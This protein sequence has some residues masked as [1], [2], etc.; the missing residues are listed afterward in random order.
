[1]SLVWPSKKLLLTAVFLLASAGCG[2]GDPGRSGGRVA[3]PGR[4][5]APAPRGTLLVSPLPPAAPAPLPNLDGPGAALV[6]PEGTELAGARAGRPIGRLKGGIPVRVSAVED[7]WAKILTPCEYE[8]WVPVSSMITLPRPRVVLDP[9]HGGGESGAVGPAGLAEKSVNLA[10]A[11]RAAELLHSRGIAALLTRTDDYR[12]TIGFRVELA[13]A[14]RP[15]LL[16]SIHHNAEPDGPRD[17]PGTETFYQIGSP[18]SRRLAGLMYEEAIRFLSPLQA[19]WVA[20]RDAGAKWR[21]NSSGGDYYG[22]L[23]RAR[24]AGI[25]AI[26]AELAFISN[27][28]EETLLAKEQTS[29]LE[30]EA[31]AQAVTRYLRT[32]DPGSGFTTPYPRDA[33]AGPGGG[34]TGCVDPS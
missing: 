33:P 6:R 30:A 12:A 24:E 4:S 25:P 31:V 32:G 3:P 8:R 28:S 1:M 19:D 21:P 20:D 5:P 15:A 7:G 9:G 27:P 34:R 10:V 26:L 2:A 29:N 23:R 16:L 14:A 11:S 13:A 17:G 22:I 18:D